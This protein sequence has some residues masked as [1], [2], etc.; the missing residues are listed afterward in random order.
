MHAE[1]PTWR[2][3]LRSLAERIPDAHPYTLA[4]RLEVDGYRGITGKQVADAIRLFKAE[5]T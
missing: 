5:E 1:R 2:Q 3:H 4:I